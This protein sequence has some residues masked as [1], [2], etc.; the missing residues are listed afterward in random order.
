M[1]KDWTPAS[2]SL[3]TLYPKDL[4]VR[5]ALQKNNKL[6]NNYKQG[7]MIL[8]DFS[9][10]QVGLRSQQ[11]TPECI[12]S[13]CQSW[14]VCWCVSVSMNRLNSALLESCK[15]FVSTFCEKYIACS[16]PCFSP[17]IV[18]TVLADAMPVKTALSD[19]VVW[20]VINNVSCNSL[21]TK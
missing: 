15:L 12:W 19:P 21:K 9:I 4:W 17:Y 14:E 16:L 3:H 1:K 5:I 2:L 18:Q 20:H 11:M 8:F 6:L 13:V 10:L 7:L